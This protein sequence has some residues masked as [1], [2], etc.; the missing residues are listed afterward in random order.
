LL[1]IDI[2]LFKQYN[3]HYGHLAGDACLREVA[4]VLQRALR[5][6][7]DMLARYGGEEF[8]LVLPNTPAAGAHKVAARL[9]RRVNQL[10][11]RHDDS[12]TNCVTI[13]VGI[14]SMVPDDSLASDSLISAADSAL[15]TAKRNG[16]N[17]VE[18]A[19]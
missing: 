1:L 9:C 19:A 17:R 11:I 12:P 5:R 6:P 3:D 16:R 15:Y 13:S 8:V 10:L 2:D 4:G 14:A 18:L 7:T